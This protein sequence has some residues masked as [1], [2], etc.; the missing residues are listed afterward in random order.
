M[1]EC[2]D[3]LGIGFLFAQNHHSAMKHAIMPRKEMAVRTLFNLLGPLTNP[4]D[5]PFQVLGV[6]VESGY[7]L[8]LRY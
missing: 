6:L 1:A 4:A 3:E 7:V 2:I 8:W 5:A